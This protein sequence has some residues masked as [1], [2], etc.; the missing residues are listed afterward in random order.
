MHMN[1]TFLI[2][3]LVIGSSSIALAQPGP[4]VRDHRTP[5]P[6]VTHQPPATVA[7][8][9]DGRVVSGGGY[10]RPTI[11]PVVRPMPAPPTWVTLANDTQLKGRTQI[12]LAPT[13]RLYSKLELRAEYGKTDINRVQIVFADGRTQTVRIDKKLV[14]EVRGRQA[15]GAVPSLTIDLA[16]SQARSIDRIIIT[17]KTGPRAAIDVLAL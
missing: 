9:D 3:A 1:K 5:A 10:L 12:K 6:V 8:I 4:I 11:R 14:A 17:G 7:Y 16:G 2:A 15:R 13:A